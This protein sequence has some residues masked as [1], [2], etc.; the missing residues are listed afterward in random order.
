MQLYFIFI[1][2]SVHIWRYS[3]TRNWI[4]WYLDTLNIGISHHGQMAHKICIFVFLSIYIIR[5]IEFYQTN[6]LTATTNTISSSSSSSTNG[7]VRNHVD[8]QLTRFT[9]FF[10]FTF[11]WKKKNSSK[12]RAEKKEDK[13]SN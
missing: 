5:Q 3:S 8:A 1:F 7:I 4:V 6:E 11:Q 13:N 10:H 2:S 12:N 9:F